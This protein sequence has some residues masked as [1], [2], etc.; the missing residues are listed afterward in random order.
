MFFPHCAPAESLMPCVD[1]LTCS[2]LSWKLWLQCKVSEIDLHFS[3]ITCQSRQRCPILSHFSLHRKPAKIVLNRQR[4]TS[5]H[6]VWL[7]NYFSFFL[8]FRLWTQYPLRRTLQ[9]FSHCPWIWCLCFRRKW[10][11]NVKLFNSKLEI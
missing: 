8:Y 11:E 1:A 9:L 4:E 6:D 2:S 7:V 5:I 3:R 10:V